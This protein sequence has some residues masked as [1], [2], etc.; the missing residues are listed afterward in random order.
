MALLGA[1]TGCVNI[2]A[3]RMPA[4]AAMH[5]PDVIRYCTFGF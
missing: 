4:H 5:D 2:L 1:G 3:V